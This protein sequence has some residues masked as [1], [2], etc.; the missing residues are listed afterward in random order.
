MSG[1][2][3]GLARGFRDVDAQACQADFAAYLQRVAEQLAD[4]KSASYDLLEP[5][6]EQRLLDVGC[7]SGDDVRALA[8]RVAPSGCVIGI[9]ISEAMI[10]QARKQNAVPCVDYCVA[11]AH[12]LPF[13]DASFD[14][15]RVE[16]VMQHVEDPDKALAEM[17][18]VVRAG[19]IVVASEPDWGT[20]AID[21]ADRDATAEVVH[22]LCDDH[23]RNAWIGRELP[24]RFVR[25]GLQVIEIHPVTLALRSFA[26]AADLFGLLEAACSAW[27]EQLRERDTRGLFFAALTGFS[28]KARVV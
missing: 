7:G 19:G 14:A 21:A 18:R 16:R 27:L 17:V 9:D 24:G 8:R 10:G 20:L 13:A 4:Q 25:L 12:A 28:V 15:A 1:R 23:I 26:V 3:S 6:S 2:G 5:A 11:D 22:A